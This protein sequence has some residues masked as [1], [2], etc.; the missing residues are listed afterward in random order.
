MNWLDRIPMVVLVMVAL[1]LAIAPITPEPHL[2]EKVRMLTQGELKRPID[3]FDLF[4]HAAPLVLLLIR[5]LR[6]A[7]TKAR[8]D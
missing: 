6:Q 2:I 8:V 4:M 1:W 3:I 5:L 7:K